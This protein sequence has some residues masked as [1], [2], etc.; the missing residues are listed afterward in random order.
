MKRISYSIIVNGVNSCTSG[1]TYCCAAKTSKYSMANYH[2]VKLEQIPSLLRKNNAINSEEAKWD[3]NALEAA[4]DKDIK[5]VKHIT[6]TEGY[7]L[8]IDAWGADPLSAFNNLQEMYF[9][10]EA[11]TAERSMILDFHTS[12]NGLPFLIDEWIDWIE[13]HNIHVQLSHDGL[14]Q[15]MRTQDIDPLRDVPRLQDAIKKGTVDWIN[16]TLNYWNWS[17]IDNMKYY[18]DI[19]KLLFP[20]A[21]TNKVF[22]KLYI[23]LNHI[24][25]SDYDIVAK[26]YNGSLC[27]YKLEALKDKPIGNLALRNDRDLA[28]KYGVEVLAH[29]LDDYI[30]EWYRLAWIMNNSN[31]IYYKPFKS[32]IMNEISR[33][34]YYKDHYGQDSGACRNFQATKHDIANTRHSTFVID[35]LGKYCECNLLDSDHSVDNPGGVLPDYCKNCRFKLSKVCNR[36]G[37]VKFRSHCEYNYAWNVFLNN[38][39]R[40][41]LI[42]NNKKEKK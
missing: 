7:T 31:W 11:F 27:G 37:A 8:H 42:N 10:F 16:C 1:C 5:E 18:I 34:G 21:V 4:L 17:P 30:A 19:L 20:D 41:R 40:L 23:K 3:F 36:C 13:E 35:T 22:N 25:D 28:D 14:G 26:N 12:T 24:Y 32:Y 15:W 33:G 2:N 39:K 6:N 38:M 29:V 9:F